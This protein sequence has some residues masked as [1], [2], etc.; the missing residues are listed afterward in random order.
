MGVVAEA[1]SLR[2]TGEGQAKEEE[3]RK[4]SLLSR[5]QVVSGA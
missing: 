2:L 3:K 1:I 4:F 5:R